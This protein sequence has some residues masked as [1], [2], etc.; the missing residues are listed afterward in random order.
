[1]GRGTL[2]SPWGEFSPP[3]AANKKAPHPLRAKGFSAVPPYFPQ[4]RPFCRRSQH[5]TG[6]AVWPTFPVR[7]KNSGATFRSFLPGDLPAPVP[8]SVGEFIP[9][10]PHP[11]PFLYL[12]CWLLTPMI[13]WD[14]DG[15]KRARASPQHAPDLRS[16]PVLEES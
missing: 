4:K 15:V 3:V 11:C 9:T 7:H 14:G 8:L 13:P 16:K 5:I 2:P 1:M 10:P 6:A 12:A